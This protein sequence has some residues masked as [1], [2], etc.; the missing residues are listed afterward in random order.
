MSICVRLQYA[1]QTTLTTTPKK[2]KKG[3]KNKTDRT[4]SQEAV[5][6]WGVNDPKKKTDIK[7]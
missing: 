7:T 3:N 5:G 1:I 2:K 6:Q 4:E